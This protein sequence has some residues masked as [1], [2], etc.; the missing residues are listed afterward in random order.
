MNRSV[1]YGRCELPAIYVK[2]YV[3]SEQEVSG[4]RWDFNVEVSGEKCDDMS[5]VR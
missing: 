1:K 3:W 4:H 2:K 5:E